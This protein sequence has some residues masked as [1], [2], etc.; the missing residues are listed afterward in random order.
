MPQQIPAYLKE[1]VAEKR[2]RVMNPY[3]SLRVASSLF[4]V[5]A[6]DPMLFRSTTK[7]TKRTK[8]NGMT[9]ALT[10]RTVLASIVV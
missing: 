7:T 6:A 5:R 1:E 9:H 8:T 3:Y 4:I 10:A 2:N